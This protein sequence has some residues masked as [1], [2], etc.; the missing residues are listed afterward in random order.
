MK[1]VSDAN[2]GNEGVIEIN[3]ATRRKISFT[4][5]ELGI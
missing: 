4:M 2:E 5:S 1:S 3:A